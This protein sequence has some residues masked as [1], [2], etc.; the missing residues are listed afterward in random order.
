MFCWRIRKCF[1]GFVCC[2]MAPNVFP[3]GCI[4]NSICDNGCNS[5]VG[6]GSGGG[7][8]GICGGSGGGISAILGSGG[9]R[10]GIVS[11]RSNWL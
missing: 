1:V 8:S 6:G 4:D 7:G 10:I 5:S 9:G 2:K 11:E 3:L